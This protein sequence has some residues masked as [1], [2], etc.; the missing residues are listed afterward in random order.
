MSNFN[1]NCNRYN[2][3]RDG[4]EINELMKRNTE[5]EENLLQLKEVLSSQI[6]KLDKMQDRR[7][8]RTHIPFSL[9]PPDLTKTAG[10]VTKIFIYL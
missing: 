9:L 10:K 4:T 1:R 5:E 3:L 2:M 7:I 8:I 6:D